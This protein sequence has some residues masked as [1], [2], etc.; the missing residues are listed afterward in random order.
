MQSVAILMF[1]VLG[2]IEIRDWQ[3]KKQCVVVG[4]RFVAM[5]RVNILQVIVGVPRAA[6]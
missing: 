1:I 4:V 6:S 2:N 3:K 5:L